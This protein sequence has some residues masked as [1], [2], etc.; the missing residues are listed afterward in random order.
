MNRRIAFFLTSP[1]GGG[2][3]RA[4][5]A[6]ANHF[7]AEG[8]QV[9][10]VFGRAEGPYR[11]EVDRRVRIVDL[12]VKRLSKM[13]LPMHRYME[14]EK[15]SV[16]V[17]PLPPC[18]LVILFGRKFLGWKTKL[19]ISVQNHPVEMARHSAALV[20]RLWPFFIRRS[21]GAAECILGI[22]SGVA[23]TVASLLGRG[24]DEVPVI[25]NPVIT[26]GFAEKLNE[27][28]GHPWFN[29]G[30]APVLLAA[31]RLTQQK[32]YPT[33]LRAFALLLRRCPARL[34]VLG[35]GEG[36]AELE[37]LASELGVSSQLA[38]PGFVRN[39]YCWMKRARLFVLSSRWE[40]FANVVAEALAC[41]VPVVSTDCPSGPGEIL[42][43]GVFGHLVPVGDAAALA[44]ALDD[45]LKQPVE[46]D[47]LV[48]RGMS[49][50]INDI[51]PRY[52]A[53]VQKAIAA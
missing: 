11:G 17:S 36:R 3:E 1:S 40:G 47:R 37:Q 4:M 34:I 39:P 7:A 53:L 14:R 20:D 5:I 50:S 10:M 31:G 44:Q 24:R 6:V 25:H 51:A 46:R 52:L 21:Y 26:P 45:A 12:S 22:S 38:M 42:G 33:L 13:L 49:Y 30:G 29:D 48:A 28:P 32:D 9:D 35:E 15:P 8:L 16:V 2:A 18:D 27:D 23:E 19:L 41:G 43:G